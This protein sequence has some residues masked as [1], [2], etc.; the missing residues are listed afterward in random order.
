MKTNAIII[1]IMIYLSMVA[2]AQTISSSYDPLN[3][4]ARIDYG[5]GTVIVYTYDAVGN[6]KTQVV[7]N[8]SQSIHLMNGS[9]TPSQGN[10]STSFTFTVTYVD[11]KG[12]T[13]TAKSVYVN[14]IAYTMILT[15]GEA[16]N[17][18]Y[19]CER[20]GLS[21]GTHAFYFIFAD[22][23]GHSIRLPASGSYTGPIISELFVLNVN[24][25]SWSVPVT[26][27]VSSPIEVTNS[28]GGGSINYS[29]TESE[30]WL[31]VSS[32]S[33]NTPAN[34]TITA[35]E[36]N[37]GAVRIGE[38]IVSASGVSGSPQIIT[39]T[40]ATDQSAVFFDDFNR[41]EI[42][43][44]WQIIKAGG[45][46]S[47]VDGQLRLYDP[48]S[49]GTQTQAFIVAE[50]TGLAD[51]TFTFDFDNGATQRQNNSTYIYLRYADESNFYY[52]A[53]NEDSYEPQLR[54]VVFIGKIIG[55][56]GS[57]LTQPMNILLSPGR[58]EFSIIGHEVRF[59]NSA[60]GSSINLYVVDN[61]TIF[62]G[63]AGF[64]VN[65]ETSV[66]DNVNLNG[67]RLETIAEYSFSEAAWY[68]VSLPI[69]PSDPRVSVLFPNALDGVAHSWNASTKSYDIVTE[70][71]PRKGYWIAISEASTSAISGA[72]LSNYTIHFTV[73]GWHMIGSIMDGLDFQNPNDNPDGMVL[74][75]A[76]LWD[77]QSGRYIA[78]TDLSG[79]NSYWLAVMGECDLTINNQQ[80]NISSTQLS[81]ASL[82]RFFADYGTTP[83]MPPTIN[84]KTGQFAEL[85]KSFV[86]HQNYPNPFNP[87]TTI[88]YDLPKESYVRINVYDIR[89]R[90][91]ALLKDQQMSVGHHIVTWRGETISGKPVASGLYLVRIEA[92]KFSSTIKMIL[93]K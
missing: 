62:A 49:S 60:G 19:S 64:R 5:N 67:T 73:A 8:S 32:T 57:L 90:H 74:T 28:G 93:I 39:V 24:P 85:P 6:R 54:Q 14:G 59:K 37:S 20:S 87:E 4:L 48:N 75:P 70:L 76:F 91:I 23:E 58:Y 40:Q 27:G 86:L 9:V 52:V 17:G 15:S 10:A 78:A 68:M 16:W 45:S 89:G 35:M 29:V 38:V 65:E 31:N 92:D 63:K 12:Q 83:P 82:T 79:K 81:K 50:G 61:E 33:G 25:T 22:A 46:A 80:V 77:A 47:I 66:F 2:S 44:N 84:W 30:S 51:A 1:I 3:R 53:I 26:G 7:T 72:P 36:N 13:P 71:E 34:F 43:N 18:I 56:T 88:E 55:G 11:S 42:G 69:V 21:A 41:T